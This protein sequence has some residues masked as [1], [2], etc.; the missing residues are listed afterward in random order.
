MSAFT[1]SLPNMKIEALTDKLPS[2]HCLICG[3]DPAMVGLF[4]PDEPLKWGA[5]TGKTR[6]IRYC[7]CSKC[8]TK[9]DTPERAEK[10]IRVEL[11]GGG[12][13]HAE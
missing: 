5:A 10:I 9:P 3:A 12:L 4:K 1:P 8:H 11:A 2:D 6:I 13:N 7:L